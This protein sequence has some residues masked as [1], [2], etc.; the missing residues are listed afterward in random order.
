MWVDDK[1]KVMKPIIDEIVG[2][3]QENFFIPD[4]RPAFESYKE[5]MS[6]FDTLSDGKDSIF[7]DCD[8]LLID[9]HIAQ[10]SEDEKTVTGEILIEQLRKKGIF[11]EVVFYSDDMKGYRSKQDKKE[12]DNVTYA[13]KTQIVGK[14]EHLIHKSVR[15]GMNISNLRGYL[16]DS[17][18][19]FDF[20]CK[21]A[22][23]Y[24]F[25]C[26]KS[27]KQKEIMAEIE[28]YI[29]EQY[30]LEAKRFCD[31][32]S[33]Y[34]ETYEAIKLLKEKLTYGTIEDDKARYDKFLAA[35]DS[36]EYVMQTSKKF[37]ILSM[38][39]TRLKIKG[40][41]EIYLYDP[42]GQ[43]ETEKHKDFYHALLIKPRN[44]FAHNKLLYGKHCGKKRIKIIKTLPD[45][46]EEKTIC[47][48]EA[49][50]CPQSYSYDE[51]LDLRKHIYNYYLTFNYLLNDV[52][53][54][55]HSFS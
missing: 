20:I 11:T 12:L 9:Y 41:N 44:D 43:S 28:K 22:A 21:E 54:K 16:M 17:T 10:K 34:K 45:E 39:L 19:E 32:N 53:K 36:Q 51:C 33:K 4:I 47:K 15:Q 8:L 29:Q 6:I 35:L 5:F 52:K 31:N 46:C 7:N 1:P 3:I 27:D 25:L 48:E 37:R 40:A 30:M 23:G 38:I 49:V 18:S 2:V 55:G 26:L 13:D 24:Y 50:V 42:N 14:V